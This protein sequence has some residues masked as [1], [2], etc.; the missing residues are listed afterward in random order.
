MKF[1]HTQVFN[2][3][4]A[5]RGMRNPLESWAK[6]DSCVKY[7]Y[8]G[9]SNW[10][11]FQY[12]EEQ[13]EF[14][15]GHNDLGLMQRLIIGGSEH[16]K[17]LRQIMLSVDITAPIYWWKEMDTYSVGVTKNSTSTMHKIMAKP[18]SKELFEID[19]IDDVELVNFDTIISICNKYRDLY[20]EHK[21]TDATT[22]KKYWKALIRALPESYLQT[23]TVTLNYEIL[24][25]I[26]HQRAGHKLTEWHQ[27]IDWVKTLPYAEELIFYN[28]EDKK[29]A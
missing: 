2:F 17:Y 5:I 28:G 4:G 7:N 6:S 29:N 3:E 27:F 16:R 15:I 9:N 18:I 11:M 1:E 23:R 25:N 24:R 14:V 21:D 19:D 8:N 22:A 20:I 26:V 10:Q 12:G 13:A